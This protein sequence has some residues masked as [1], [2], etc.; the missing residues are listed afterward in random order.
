MEGGTYAE[1]IIKLGFPDHLDWLAKPQLGLL[2]SKGF[3]I[4]LEIRSSRLEIRDRVPGNRIRARV[5]VE[6]ME[7]ENEENSQD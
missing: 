2:C 1:D 4:L 7:R 6:R 5:C 3:G